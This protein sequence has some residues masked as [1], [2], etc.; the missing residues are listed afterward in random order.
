M[1][2]RELSVWDFVKCEPKKE[3]LDFISQGLYINEVDCSLIYNSHNITPL[4][5]QEDGLDILRAVNNTITCNNLVV[6][7]SVILPPSIGEVKYVIDEGLYI[8][9]GEDWV[10][11]SSIEPV[12]EKINLWTRIK[13]FFNIKKRGN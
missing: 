13:K 8:F 10:K 2:K 5:V 3:L 12:V 7:D 9:T 11:L 1:V 4:L 6:S